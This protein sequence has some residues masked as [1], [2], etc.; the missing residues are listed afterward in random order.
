[1]NKKKILIIDDEDDFCFFV[2]L[3]LQKTGKYQ[4]F[5]ATSGMEGLS[6]A[7]QHKPDFIFLDMVMPKMG[8]A[9]VAKNLLEDESTRMIPVVFV[10]A[11]MKN[12][13]IAESGGHIGARDFIAKPVT[14]EKLIE[15]LGQM[16][17]N[18]YGSLVQSHIV[19]PS[20][21]MCFFTAQHMLLVTLVSATIFLASISVENTAD[22]S[23]NSGQVT[24]SAKVLTRSNVKMLH[25]VPVTTITGTDIR[26]GYIDIKSAVRMEIKSN[27]PGGLSLIFRGIEWP[28]EKIH[29]KGLANET[30]ISSGKTFIYQPY[31]H[32]TVAIE[33]DYR[34]FFIEGATPGT[35][36]L[37][38]ILGEFF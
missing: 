22:A 14:P 31:N 33:L 15:K 32:G 19:G 38:R 7:R 26:R 28:F 23:S 35:Y 17:V 20:M 37:P 18:N 11:V 3:N 21:L 25:H 24:V 6:L 34:L 10:S 36:T 9:E 29:V 12:Y 16:L 27:K 2:K 30:Q 8:G 5:T 13:E 4:V 1:M